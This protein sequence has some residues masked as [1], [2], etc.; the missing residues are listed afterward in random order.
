MTEVSATAKPVPDLTRPGSI[1]RGMFSPAAP[2]RGLLLIDSAWPAKQ[3]TSGGLKGTFFL[4]HHAATGSYSS[5][6][7]HPCGIGPRWTSSA[8]SLHSKVMAPKTCIFCGG[9]GPLTKDHVVTKRTSRRIREFRGAL[10]FTTIHHKEDGSTT[11]FETEDFAV[12]PKAVCK[13]CNTGW[14]RKLEERVWPIMEPMIIG[15]RRTLTLRRQALLAA[16]IMA[17][18][19]VAEFAGFPVQLGP[20]FTEAERFA[21]HQ[22]LTPPGKLFIWIAG[23]T[24]QLAGHTEGLHILFKDDVR[25]YLAFITQDRLV[26]VLF[27]HRF[28]ER[29]RWTFPIGRSV[30]PIW[31]PEAKQEWPPPYPLDEA[32]IET[33]RKHMAEIE[34]E[35]L[36]PGR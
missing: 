22:L 17:K 35:I 14:M 1:L 10:T 18:V 12:A 31:K 36:G 5:R 30:A 8:S 19:M 26:M 13:R 24:S 23:T 15:Q 27:A 9:P 16:Y 28:K 32:Q 20:Y 33:W 11:E 4:I 6:L 29:T 3:E 2:Q 25:G 21:F 7:V 34:P